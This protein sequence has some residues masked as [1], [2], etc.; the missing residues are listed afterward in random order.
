MG[1]RVGEAGVAPQEDPGVHCAVSREDEQ[2]S[3][4]QRADVAAYGNEAVI[5]PWLV[6]NVWT[7]PENT[8]QSCLFLSILM[9]RNEGF[10]IFSPICFLCVHS[11]HISQLLF[12]LHLFHGAANSHTISDKGCAACGHH[13]C[14]LSADRWQCY[15]VV[16]SYWTVSVTAQ[17]VTKPSSWV[18][19]GWIIEK[20]DGLRRGGWEWGRWETVDSGEGGKD[21]GLLQV[22]RETNSWLCVPPRQ[23]RAL[24]WRS[25]PINANGVEATARQ[26]SQFIT[27]CAGEQLGWASRFHVVR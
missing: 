20:T 12:G 1:T 7:G 4:E 5:F 22:C 8:R 23:M 9:K 16:Q 3:G 27:L 6:W 11:C 26:N 17:H 15:S 19:A 14:N 18:C 24:L 2:V 21:A 13:V 25:C 10:L